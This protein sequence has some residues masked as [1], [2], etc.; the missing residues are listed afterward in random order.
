MS[1]EGEAPFRVR[2]ADHG[3]EA[4]IEVVV[5]RAFAKEALASGREAEIVRELRAKRRVRMIMVAED[6]PGQLVGVLVLSPVRME[7]QATGWFGL[8][9]VA[10]VPEWQRR[11]VGSAMIGATMAT[12]HMEH[13]NGCVVL[14]EPKFYERF[15]FRRLPNLTLPGTPEGYFLALP[16]DGT[17]P[18][19]RVRYH[20][21][22]GAGE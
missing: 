8:G 10:V 15:G 14:G 4:F 20:A 3:D 11:G 9:P 16:F 12:L 18:E 21:A 22:F 2:E 1:A 5:E 19:G 7:N 13:A 17:T 6:G